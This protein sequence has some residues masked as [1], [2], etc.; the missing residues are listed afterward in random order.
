MKFPL[1]PE[2]RRAQFSLRHVFAVIVALSVCLALVTQL[3]HLGWALSVGVVGL[4]VGWWR[5]D[6]RLSAAAGTALSIFVLTYLA[7]WVRMDEELM[8]IRPVGET[9]Y[10]FHRNSTAIDEYKSING[11]LPESLHELDVNTLSVLPR[12]DGWGGEI[13]YRRHD[14]EYELISFGRDRQ[15]GGAGLDADLVY[16]SAEPSQ[17]KFA[18]LTVRQFLF[19]ADGSGGIFQ[20][21]VVASLLTAVTWYVANWGEDPNR[22][23]IFFELAIAIAS[24]VFAAVLLAYFYVAAA[25][26]N[27]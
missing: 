10:I 16:R 27:H 22:P 3:R 6:W 12:I 20:A 9:R 24:A 26:S 23:R 14:D 25:G 19:E 1:P 7:S 5:G 18:P 11:S 2:Q 13:R 4:G 8:Q 21:A 17:P 15:P